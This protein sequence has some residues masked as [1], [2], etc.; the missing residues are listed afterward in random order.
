MKQVRGNGL[1]KRS[2]QGAGYTRK[3]AGDNESRPFVSA[4][5]DTDKLGSP[6]VISDGTKCRTIGRTDYPPKGERR[7]RAHDKDVVARI[8]NLMFDIPT[9]QRP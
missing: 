9:F 8:F 2:K 6:A 1:V 7:R 5:V 4:D 3:S